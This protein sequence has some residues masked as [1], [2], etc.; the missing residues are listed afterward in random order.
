LDERVFN[1]YPG[2]AILGATASGKTR[3]AID[4]ALQFRGEIVSCDALQV[5]RHMD[6]G[7]AKIPMAE[8]EGIRHHML[9]VQEPDF[10]FER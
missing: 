6:I 9:D 3:L 7:T 2:I 10:I 4:L 5:Y 8:R 1:E